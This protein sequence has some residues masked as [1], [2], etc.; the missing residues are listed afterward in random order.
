MA[1]GS[2]A[3]RHRAAPLLLAA[4]L[5]GRS[6]APGIS[7]LAKVTS[8]PSPSSEVPAPAPALPAPA[9]PSPA[10]LSP[11]STA[12]APRFAPLLRCPASGDRAA[13][14][15]GTGGGHALLQRQH[16]RRQVIVFQSVRYKDRSFACACPRRGDRPA[17]QGR[18]LEHVP[19]PVSRDARDPR[20]QGAGR[21]WQAFSLSTA[22][23]GQA[24]ATCISLTHPLHSCSRGSPSCQP[25]T[26]G[27]QC[28]ACCWGTP[29]GG[30]LEG[31]V[32]KLKDAGDTKKHVC[33]SWPSPSPWR[34]RWGKPTQ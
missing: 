13:C 20:A 1:P 12:A 15:P 27:W 9:L 8:Q 26:E 3:A 24:P 14:L 34:C 11:A 30:V 18:C 17:L 22:H 7:H 19:S 33:T 25:G 5:D 29:V 23:L 21:G 10:L 32:L 31:K 2:P 16:A 6:G 28:S 4:L